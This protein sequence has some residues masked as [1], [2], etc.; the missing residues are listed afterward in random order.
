MIR[1]LILA[2]LLLASCGQGNADTAAAAQ[3]HP[4]RP[5]NA[6]TALFYGG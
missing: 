3:R 5:R 6:Q 2:A 1:K 4:P